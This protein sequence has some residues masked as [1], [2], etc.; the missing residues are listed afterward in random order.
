MQTTHINVGGEYKTLTHCTFT[1]VGGRDFQSVRRPFQ[2]VV[3]PILNLSAESLWSYVILL[4]SAIKY[5][6]TKQERNNVSN[7]VIDVEG[8]LTLNRVAICLG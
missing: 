2:I 6:R 8:F 1:E 7:Y 4:I 5:M 3:W